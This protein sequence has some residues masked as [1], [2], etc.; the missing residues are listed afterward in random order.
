MRTFI[1]I[2][3]AS[4]L[5]ITASGCNSGSAVS[6]ATGL[7]YE[8]VVVMDKAAW[9]GTTGTAVKEEL[10]APVPYLLNTEPSM[11]VMHTTP[12]HFDGI[13][14]YVRNILIVNINN[15]QYTKV[16]VR[17]E[18]DKWAQGQAVF[19]LNAPDGQ[20]IEAFLKENQ[21]VL[22]D[23]Y[24]K[25]EMKRSVQYL[26][27]KYSPEVMKKVKEKF[28]ITLNAPED[29]KHFKEGENS[30]WFSND[31]TTGHMNLLIYSFPFTDT[32]TFTLEYLVSQRDSVTKH[33]LPGSFEG[34][35]V[36]T[37][38]RVVDYS[39]T[40][41][42]GEYC[43]VLRG[44]WRMEGGDMMGGPF[45]SYARVDKPNKRVIVTD[46]FVYEPQKEKRNYLRRIEAALQTTRFFGEQETEEETTDPEQ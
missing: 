24:T 36:A 20:A 30:L 37:E 25:E 23:L 2:L 32:N 31:A 22:V 15:K 44:L 5:L 19:Y 28:G 40:T 10:T 18:N 9:D 43:G 46:G 27:K 42:H 33:M 21:R 4:L 29:I 39:A 1:F 41:L 14:K 8:I 13:L 16:S 12:E 6:R 34:S 26:S 45:V 7:A 38:K 35:Y 17:K 3:F 11:K